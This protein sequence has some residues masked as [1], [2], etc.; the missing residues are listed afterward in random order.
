MNVIIK[1]PA[2]ESIEAQIQKAAAKIESLKI[3]E[4]VK[5]LD[6]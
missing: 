2:Q 3:E 6:S 4:T 1:F 5:E